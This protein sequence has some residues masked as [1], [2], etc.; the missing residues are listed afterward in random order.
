MLFWFHFHPLLKTCK[1]IFQILIFIV[2][3]LC[4]IQSVYPKIYMNMWKY[5]AG[6]VTDCV[7]AV[8][9]SLNAARKYGKVATTEKEN[10]MEEIIITSHNIGGGGI[11]INHITC[12]IERWVWMVSCRVIS[13]RHWLTDG[14]WSRWR[15]RGGRSLL[16]CRRG[17]Y[18]CNITLLLLLL[19]V[20]GGHR[21]VRVDLLCRD[22]SLRGVV[23]GW[24]LVRIADM[25]LLARIAGCWHCA[26][27]WLSISL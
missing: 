24:L 23:S 22:T 8:F 5:E 17:M 3:V 9:C 27:R 20:C 21:W 4:R 26:R 18:Y 6:R 10:R 13:L 14:C 12:I 11:F 7:A 2:H 25:W 19:S 15:L 1:L 16:Y